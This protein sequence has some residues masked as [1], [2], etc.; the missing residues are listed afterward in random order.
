[1]SHWVFFAEHLAVFKHLLLLGQIKM[2]R[3]HLFLLSTGG[4]YTAYKPHGPCPPRRFWQRGLRICKIVFRVII[5]I[6]YWVRW[7]AA[8]C[9]NWGVDL[10]VPPQTQN[11]WFPLVAAAQ[12]ELRRESVMP[13]FT[14][15]HK[16]Q[17]CSLLFYFPSRGKI[18]TYAK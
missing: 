15:R 6:T 2:L 1:M 5:N 10:F 13:P 14:T 9:C 3:H 11:E 8:V 16:L 18:N 17:L 4:I 12:T 7:F